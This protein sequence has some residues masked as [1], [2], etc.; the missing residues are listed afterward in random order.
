MRSDPPTEVVCDDDGVQ[1]F[2]CFDP[3]GLELELNC[4][5]RAG[6]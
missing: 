4:H 3:N 6:S 1:T 5:P 2:Y